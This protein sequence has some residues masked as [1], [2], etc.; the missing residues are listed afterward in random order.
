MYS[1]ARKLSTFCAI[2]CALNITGLVM[3][4]LLS[5]NAN[6]PFYLFFTCCIYAV[7]TTSIAL[8]LTLAVRSFVQDANLDSENTSIRIKKLNDRIHLLESK[9]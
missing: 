5:F 2:L 4:G 7:S 6:L 8:F 1:T 3:L 9:K